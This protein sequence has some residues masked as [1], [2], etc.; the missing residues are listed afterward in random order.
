MDGTD[1]LEVVLCELV[2]N[3]KK[4]P[5]GVGVCKSP[6]A[7]AVGW[8]Q[9]LFQKLTTHFLNLQ[10]LEQASWGKKGKWSTA[11]LLMW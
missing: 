4:V 9:L 11:Q 6:D 2:S 10:H 8:M 7:Q 5:T 1:L 3:A